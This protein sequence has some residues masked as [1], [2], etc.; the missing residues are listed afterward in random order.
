MIVVDASALIDWVLRTPAGLAVEE[1]LLRHAGTLEAP[2]FVA[3]ECA[4]GL[5]RLEARSV[6]DTARADL[7]FEAISRLPMTLHD[8]ARFMPRVWALR[9]SLTS[10]DAAYVALAETLEVPLL[11]C[12]ARLARSR[13]HTPSVILAE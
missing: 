4:N 13:G 11:T 6:L 12:D 3:V 7:S 8:T 2:S 10:Y 5:R 9:H 1:H